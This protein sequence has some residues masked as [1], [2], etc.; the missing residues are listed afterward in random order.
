MKGV[1]GFEG[2]PTSWDFCTNSEPDRFVDAFSGT[3]MAIGEYLMAEMLER[4]AIV[5]Q[6]MLPRTLVAD[7][8]NGEPSDLLAGDWPDAAQL[9]ADHLLSLTLDGQEGSIAALLRSFSAGASAS[10]PDVR[11]S[12]PMALRP[13]S[14]GGFIDA[15]GS[16]LTQDLGVKIAV[17]LS[18]FEVRKGQARDMLVQASINAGGVVPCSARAPD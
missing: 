8:L 10:T 4:Q 2:T 5:V 14:T 9:L 15:S 13:R 11:R 17:G 6:S 3:D 1:R 16:W 7:R 12:F 18:A